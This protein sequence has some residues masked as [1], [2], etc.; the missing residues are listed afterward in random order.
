MLHY[1]LL[2]SDW[3][4]MYVGHIKCAEMH[5]GMYLCVTPSNRTERR[6]CS[7]QLS[8]Y[9][10]SVQ[11]ARRHNPVARAWLSSAE[12]F[13]QLLRLSLYH[14]AEPLGRAYSV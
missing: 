14:Q 7:T 12:Q 9:T 11:L 5:I 13:N 8:G 1:A 2:A 6:V 4:S 3:M 10:Y